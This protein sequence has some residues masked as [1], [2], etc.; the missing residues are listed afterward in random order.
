M[1]LLHLKYAVV[2]AETNSMTRAA[3]KLYTAQPNLSRAIRELEGTLGITIFKRTSKGIYPTPE[4]EEFLGYARKILNQVDEIEEMYKGSGKRSRKFSISVP[5]ASYIACAFTDFVKMMDVSESAEYFYKETNAL[6]AVNNV[7]G[8]DY[9][10]GIIRYQESFDRNFKDMLSEKSLH[11]EMVFEFR[12]RLLMSAAH[13]LAQKQ[14]ICLSD[15]KPYVE[16]AHADPYI[17]S[18]SLSAAR[19]NEIAD[20]TD[21][22]IFVFERASQMDILS[23][24]SNT[25]MWVSPV[26][27]RLLEKYNL[28]E[29][30][31]DDF[32]RV[33]KDLLIYRE[34]YRLTETDQMFIDKLMEV[35]RG[36]NK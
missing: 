7:T 15:L 1:N 34:G 23:E 4:G 2:I 22:I 27:G 30:E 14:I 10:L 11:G 17:P 12:Y 20:D 18:L 31:C 24:S 35:K 16:I 5:R 33:Y 9:R 32:S 36:L 19:K 29:R 6:R 8:E 26:P 28:V 3:D 21:K 13:P 25:F